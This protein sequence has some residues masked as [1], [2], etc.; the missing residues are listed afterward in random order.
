MD[1]LHKPERQAN[2]TQAEYRARQRASR[3]AVEASKAMD[4]TPRFKP[5]SKKLKTLRERIAARKANTGQNPK[6]KAERERKPKAAIKPTWPRT[7]DQ[8]LQSRPVH[9]LNPNRERDP[10]KR[11]APKSAVAK[12]MDRPERVAMIDRGH[13]KLMRFFGAV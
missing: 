10:G 4:P 6:F 3:E 9:N 12:R 2:E 7:P 13:A 1:T 11:T 5:M 8:Q